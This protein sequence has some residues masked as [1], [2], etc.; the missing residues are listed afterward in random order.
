MN[1]HVFQKQINIKLSFFHVILLERQLSFP[2]IRAQQEIN[3]SYT[4]EPHLSGH[5]RSQTD[6]PDN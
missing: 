3:D 6:C 4:V 1:V 5:F 2:Q